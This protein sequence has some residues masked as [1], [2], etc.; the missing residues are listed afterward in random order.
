MIPSIAQAHL[1]HTVIE[2]GGMS[3]HLHRFP[4][5]HFQAV[6]GLQECSCQICWLRN[7]N[8]SIGSISA[9]RIALPK[10]AARLVGNSEAFRSQRNCRF[11][12]EYTACNRSKDACAQS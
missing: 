1:E 6:A 5:A 11:T 4:S 2:S 7:L 9:C 12:R 10:R 3:R 8:L